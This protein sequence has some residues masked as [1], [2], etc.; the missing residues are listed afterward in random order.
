MSSPTDPSLQRNLGFRGAYCVRSAWWLELVGPA[1]SV[2][3]AG[4]KVSSFE[5][6]RC[7][8][9]QWVSMRM[10]NRERYIYIYILRSEAVVKRIPALRDSLK[11]THLG[12]KGI[13]NLALSTEGTRWRNII[14]VEILFTFAAI[15]DNIMEEL[16]PRCL[17][18]PSC[19][20]RELHWQTV[21]LQ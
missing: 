18:C 13:I 17:V 7:V 6:T 4:I 1:L 5:A 3:K 2:I 14:R 16:I 12:N 10:I 11:G 20:K 15:A 19:Q 9:T 8:M 21:T